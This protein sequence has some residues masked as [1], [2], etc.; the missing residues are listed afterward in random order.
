MN[1]GTITRSP[2]SF[3]VL[4]VDTTPRCWMAKTISMMKAP[5]KNA[6]FSET[7]GKNGKSKL[8]SDQDCRAGV[9]AA[10]TAAIASAAVLP[11]FAGSP[12][13]ATTCGDWSVK[14]GIGAMALRI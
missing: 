14:T 5:M 3:C 2:I 13:H 1:I 9:L 10:V 11:A 7:A 8:T 4:A 12:S 6:T